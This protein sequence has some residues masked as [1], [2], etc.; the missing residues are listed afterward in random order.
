MGSTHLIF[1]LFFLSYLKFSTAQAQSG[2]WNDL[3]QSL[4]NGQSTQPKSV[5]EVEPIL[6]SLERK[7]KR[8][9][10]IPENQSSLIKF[11]SEP[12]HKMSP[13][14]C[15][16][17][18]IDNLRNLSNANL[19]TFTRQ[20][21]AKL[22]SFCDYKFRKAFQYVLHEWS[23][24]KTVRHLA[25]GH[26]LD[27]PLSTVEL[28]SRLYDIMIASNRQLSNVYKRKYMS[29][30]HLDE[31]VMAFKRHYSRVSPCLNLFNWREF[32]LDYYRFLKTPEVYKL[33][34]ENLKGLVN[35]LNIC[36]IV[37]G[38]LEIHQIT[39]NKI[40]DSIR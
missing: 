3:D 17:D 22:I 16:S 40:L 10:S 23:M 27:R 30:I 14:M 39:L 28:A 7:T 18:Y 1:P 37:D 29:S 11:W 33:L 21:Y 4:F 35:K 6:D 2:C 9:E 32:N 31:N 19:E 15:S 36:E 34:E 12:R 26:K 13:A 25:D 8:G 24:K 5:T 20:I 38:S